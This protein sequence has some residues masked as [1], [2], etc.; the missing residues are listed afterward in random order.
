MEVPSMSAIP[1]SLPET[2]APVNHLKRIV[3]VFFS[4]KET[5]AEIVAAPSWLVPM[6]L[7]VALSALACFALNQRMDWRSFIAQ[8][9]EKSPQSANLSPEQKE[10]RV[11]GGVKMAP[12]FAYIFGVPAPAIAI[13]VVAAVMLGAYNLFAGAGASFSQAMGIVAHT[14]LTSIVSTAIFLLV[15]FIKPV[16]TF[17]LDNPVA[18]NLGV[19]VPE[20]AAK[21]LMTLGKSIDIFSFWM[22]ILIA[23]GFAAVAPRKLKFGKAFGIALSVWGVFVLVKVMWA[24]IFT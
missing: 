3:G 12:M 24:W 5:F 23:I 14:F 8:Q 1:S 7:L 21:W 2:H 19:L 11:E 20:D 16:G 13:L 6:V 4:P 10:Q 9:I 22:L 17:D 18:T 15:L